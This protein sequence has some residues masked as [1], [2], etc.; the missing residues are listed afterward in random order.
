MRITR[1]EAEGDGV[2]VQRRA[3]FRL[4]A[5]LSYDRAALV[6]RARPIS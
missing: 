1:T 6:P 2:A 5:Y 3:T 4:R